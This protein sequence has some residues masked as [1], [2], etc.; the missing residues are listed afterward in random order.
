MSGWT[1]LVGGAVNGASYALLALGLVLAYRVSG[2]VNFAHGVTATLA[3]Y[4]AFAAYD[5]GAPLAFTAAFVAAFAAGVATEALVTRVGPRGG[6]EAQLLVTI[7]LFMLGDGLL[8]AAFGADIRA[9]EHVFAG[10]DDGPFAPGAPASAADLLL[11]AVCSAACAALALA[12]RTPTGLATRA[13]FEDPRGAARLGLP[14]RRLSML[15]WGLSG[16]LGALAGLLLVPRLF[17]E[18]GALFGPLLR[19]F[20][21]ATIGGFGSVPAALLGGLGLGLTEALAGAA[22]APLLQTSLPFLVMLVALLLRPVG[23]TGRRLRRRL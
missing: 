16:A 1:H 12:A 17:L 18:P 5:L 10:L 9:F 20:A 3:A 13:V 6:H 4:V 14:V 11:L 15:T 2:V 21:A 19:A 22:G 7:A 8:G 23:L